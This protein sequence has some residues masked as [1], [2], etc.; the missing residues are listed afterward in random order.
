M[1]TSAVQRNR[2]K[3]KENHSDRE[4]ESRSLEALD[5]NLR[6]IL[7]SLAQLL[8]ANGYG[9][10]RL[11]KLAKISFVNAAKSIDSANGERIN[12][13]RIAALTGLTRTEVSQL[14]RSEKPDLVQSFDS[15]N[16]SFRVVQGW[17]TDSKFLSPDGT[18]RSL[19]FK[20]RNSS[21]T[22]LVK[23]YSGD[24]PARA[25]LTEMK[26]LRIVRHDS[27][28]F[29][30]LVRTTLDISRKTMLAMKAIS[31]W[32]GM[33]TTGNSV[34]Q[35]GEVASKIKQV[36]L[37]FSSLPQLLAAVRELE[38]RR[39][40]FVDGLEQ[41]GNEAPVNRKHSLRISIAV[42]A[43]KAVVRNKRR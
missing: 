1:G 5:S 41:L 34:A 30:H 24:I 2:N 32:V 7:D 37:T 40:A 20:G 4:N 38:H 35:L 11:G 18:P 17:L 19:Q 42:A 33:L 29:V 26:R 8:V 25:M 12:K 36:N 27:Q 16:R 10:S 14:L 22:H 23:N 9:F 6:V 3:K 13:A 43:Q 21:F 39:A 15:V 31:P 28:D